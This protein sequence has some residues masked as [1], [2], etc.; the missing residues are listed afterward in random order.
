MAEYIEREA[1][2]K[3]AWDA[4]TRCGYVQ[5][6]DVG[7]ILK[8]P[9]ADVVPR[10]AY[11]QA[12]WERDIAMKQLE[13]HGIPFGGKAD[14]VA[15]VRCWECKHRGDEMV[16]PMCHERCCDDGDG[17]LDVWNEDETK[18][19]GFCHKGERREEDGT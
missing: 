11:E 15:V 17:H 5:V 12:V 2:I 6:V 14:V 3:K 13:E 18:D 1:L 16:C 19:N 9:A 8:A 10:A 4:D 7:D